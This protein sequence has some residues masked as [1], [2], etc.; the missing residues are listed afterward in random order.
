MGAWLSA[1]F[2]AECSEVQKLVL[3]SPVSVV[4]DMS[5]KAI[6]MG[7]LPMIFPFTGKYFMKV[8]FKDFFKST[9]DAEKTF[10]QEIYKPIKMTKKCLKNIPPLV[11]EKFS[12]KQ[13]N[14]IKCETLYLVGKNE[15]LYNIEEGINHFRNSIYGKNPL[16]ISL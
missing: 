4:A 9:T 14:N 13:L 12:E 10:E 16:I 1:L 5:F 15:I 7:I 2:A 6:I 11:P 3:I 8:Y